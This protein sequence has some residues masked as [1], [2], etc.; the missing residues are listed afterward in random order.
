MYENQLMSRLKMRVVLKN[1]FTKNYLIDPLAK[2]LSK[3]RKGLNLFLSILI[4]IPTLGIAHAVL[5]YNKSQERF[6][7]V[8]RNGKQFH[9]KTA[10]HWKNFIGVK[11]HPDFGY[12][13]P[14][15]D[16][17][18]LEKL[19]KEQRKRIENHCLE[20]MRASM[21]VL[22]SSIGDGVDQVIRDDV[23]ALKRSKTE[24]GIEPVKHPEVLET[25]QTFSKRLVDLYEAYTLV[26]ADNHT[27]ILPSSLGVMKA[28][29]FTHQEILNLVPTCQEYNNYIKDF[30]EKLKIIGINEQQAYLI[31]VYLSSCQY[32]KEK[33]I[34]Q[35][36]ESQNAKIKQIFFEHPEAET[37]SQDFLNRLANNPQ[38]LKKIQ[39]F[40]QRVKFA[41][42]LM[43]Q[44]EKEDLKK[45]LGEFDASNSHDD[46]V[47]WLVNDPKFR[48]LEELRCRFEWRDH[49]AGS[50]GSPLNLLNI[51]QGKQDA[52]S[53][54]LLY[55]IKLYFIYGSKG[56]VNEVATSPE[57][58]EKINAK[59]REKGKN[60]QLDKNLISVFRERSANEPVYS[61]GVYARQNNVGKKL[62][63]WAT[64]EQVQKK[65]QEDP[66]LTFAE[67]ER[68][69]L[70]VNV[71]SEEL[72][73]RFRL[74]LVPQEE[75]AFFG[76]NS[77]I[78]RQEINRR[79]LGGSKTSQNGS[80]SAD[81]GFY[82][83]ALEYQ[84][85]NKQIHWLPGKHIFNLHSKSVSRSSYSNAIESLGLPQDSG[86]S[87]SSDQTFTMAGILG[88]QSKEELMALRLAYLPWM[89]RHEDHTVHEIMTAVKSFGLDY[90]PSPD[91][92]K[93]IYPE[94]PV[95][96]DAIQTAQ[97]RRGY[98][99]PDYYLSNEYV[100]KFIEAEQDQKV[101][102]LMS[103]QQLILKG[104]RTYRH[105]YKINDLFG[106]KKWS[107]QVSDL[108]PKKIDKVVQERLN[109]RLRN[110][111][112]QNNKVKFVLNPQTQMYEPYVRSRTA[113]YKGTKKGSVS[114]VPPS[115]KIIP[116][117]PFD[118]PHLNRAGLLFDANKSEYKKDKFIFKADA[119]VDLEQKW[120]KEYT[121]EETE[122]S[123]F[124]DR[125]AT[126]SKEAV[127]FNR[128]KAYQVS[129]EELS[130]EFKLFGNEFIHYNEV[131][132]SLKPEG[133]V[134]VFC[135][136][137][138]L[139]TSIPN[140]TVGKS[141]KFDYTP[142]EHET[143]VNFTGDTDYD[144]YMRLMGTAKKIAVRKQFGMDVP[145]YE[146]N[147][148][149]DQGLGLISRDE[150]IREIQT[151]LKNENN[152]LAGLVRVIKHQ[153]DIN[154]QDE[155]IKQN[156]ENTLR[157]YLKVL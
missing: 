65:L 115:G 77:D 9:I 74:Q 152:E 18:G 60:W 73:K 131:L 34:S 44:A 148:T 151:I 7:P 122:A 12:V 71:S 17:K 90:T 76:T 45:E 129:Q 119:N 143:V 4:G 96:V 8:M 2:G 54:D 20:Q 40:D 68:I 6:H 103:K 128:E 14:K 130:Q 30:E 5:F 139:P 97:R 57:M 99:L 11:N 22:E 32:S 59:L 29:G 150:Q 58:V 93:Q 67:G 51:I 39:S 144:R 62:R 154:A 107:Q 113:F 142:L 38:F 80:H 84:K 27:P 137:K 23:E 102:D 61:L 146:I 16:M 111:T 132:A 86:I 43:S 28:S 95:L 117:V 85:R 109:K 31:T 121:K 70:G 98:E 46:H 82:E 145:L 48:L 89:S 136:S 156:L 157:G 153:T 37:I 19:P 94:S 49:E 35:I 72:Q 141:S 36:E 78:E 47:K 21:K 101:Q 25:V 92:Y 127:R 26:Q 15:V 50:V 55:R 155:T 42:S 105:N 112:N 69:A 138:G 118:W 52:S 64:H 116:Y 91:F 120:K 104:L 149:K 63:N 133:I 79:E 81:T 124:Q 123:D 1:L 110:Q 140:A 3:K 100:K 24:A 41:K 134:G 87:G 33:S 75:M 147:V 126:D 88:I 135:F 125:L 53:K 13:R 106:D 114:I 108:T 83:S 66:N 10:K 56:L